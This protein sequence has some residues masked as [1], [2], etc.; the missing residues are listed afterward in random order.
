VRATATGPS[1]T[2]ESGSTGFTVAN[3][4]A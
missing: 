1:G 3:C 2:A 4:P